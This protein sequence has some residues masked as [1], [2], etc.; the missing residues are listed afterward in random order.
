MAMPK[1]AM[2]TQKVRQAW[3]AMTPL[4]STSCTPMAQGLG[5]RY[6]GMLK[7]EQMICHS[8]MVATS[9]IQGTSAHGFLCAWD[10]A[11]SLFLLLD[12]RACFF[13][14]RRCGRAAR[15]RCR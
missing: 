6:S 13:A 11:L 5:N 2:V 3:P 4:N 7:A 12:G 10:E 1:P 14:G 8:R 15:A 9:R